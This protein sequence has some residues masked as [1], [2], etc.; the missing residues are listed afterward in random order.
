MCCVELTVQAEKPAFKVSPVWTLLAIGLAILGVTAAIA[1][2]VLP[3]VSATEMVLIVGAT[4]LAVLVGAALVYRRYLFYDDHLTQRRLYGGRRDLPYGG[5]VLSVPYRRPRWNEP[6]AI[7][8][9]REPASSV[10]SIILLKNP[11]NRQLGTDLVSWLATKV[12]QGESQQLQNEYL[13]SLGPPGLA[14]FLGILVPVMA[15]AEAQGYVLEA[16]AVGGLASV[17]LFALSAHLQFKVDTKFKETTASRMDYFISNV[18]ALVLAQLGALFV[19]AYY[20]LLPRLGVLTLVAVDGIVVSALIVFSEFP[21]AF[22]VG[23]RVS[24]I[25]DGP[26]LSSFLALARQ[27]GIEHVDFYSVDWRMF[28]VANAFQ[29]GPTRFSVYVSNYL[30]EGMTEEEAKAVVAHELAHAQRRHVA[31]GLALTLAFLLVTIDIFVSTQL[32]NPAFVVPMLVGG[33]AAIVVGSRALVHFRRNYEFEADEVAVK[34][35][36]EG[37]STEGA[38][39]KLAKLNLVPGDRDSATHPSVSKR[40]QRIERLR[41]TPPNKKFTEPFGG[42]QE[43]ELGQG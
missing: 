40:I 34:T 31:K 32:V 28:K 29:V 13:R 16:M 37:A 41:V 23:R 14:S 19:A 43:S 26:L 11:W 21:P 38:L 15:V 18:P 42:I 24:P 8:K 17:G 2:A 35:M 5:L 3:Y 25:T 27:M 1:W 22:R 20:Y 7:L 10:K 9:P 30:L 33:M 36:G 6:K 39:R 12:E 4:A